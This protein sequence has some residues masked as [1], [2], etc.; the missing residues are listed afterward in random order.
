VQPALA[1]LDDHLA[2][3]DPYRVV[4]LLLFQHGADSA[5][6]ARPEDWARTI[7]AHGATPDFLGMDPAKFPHDI[8]FLGRYGAALDG[9][10][11]ARHL[12]GS[13]P[14]ARALRGLHD[15]G[16]SIEGLEA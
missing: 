1:A 15:H 14:L 6:I 8:G 16:L 4:R 13:L 12:W 10:P 11:R 2:R 9:L 5:G 7:S 3:S